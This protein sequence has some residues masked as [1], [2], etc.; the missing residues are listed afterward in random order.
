MNH[1][2]ATFYSEFVNL[3]IFLFLFLERTSRF[4]F[5]FCKVFLII[6]TK[7]MNSVCQLL[8]KHLSWEL[9]VELDLLFG[10]CCDLPEG[11]NRRSE[12][13]CSPMSLESSRSLRKHRRTRT[14][15]RTLP[16]YATNLPRSPPFLTAPDYKYI[17]SQRL[18]LH[19]GYLTTFWLLLKN[20]FVLENNFLLLI[21]SLFVLVISGFDFLA[22]GGKTQ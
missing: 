21:F 12:T 13:S 5:S 6:I 1:S 2:L 10:G 15:P 16:I 22:A 3:W 7:N 11:R 17:I 4:K 20:R 8:E 9:S 19:Y 18:T 14:R